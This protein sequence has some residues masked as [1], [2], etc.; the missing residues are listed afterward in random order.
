MYFSNTW[1]T[2]EEP[3][4][5]KKALWNNRKRYSELIKALRK[6]KGYYMLS[7]GEN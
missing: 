5:S 7:T 6:L 3:V 2:G 4:N 1:I